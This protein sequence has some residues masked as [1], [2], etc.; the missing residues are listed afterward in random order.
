MGNYKMCDILETAGR[1][2]KRTTIWT[3]GVSIYYIYRVL[4]DCWL[5]K[6]SLGLLSAFPIFDDLVSRKRLV[7]KQNLSTS[8]TRRV[9]HDNNQVVIYGRVNASSFIVYISRS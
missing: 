9:G 8:Y 6:F 5:F 2:A 3:S 1:R 7:V 4:F